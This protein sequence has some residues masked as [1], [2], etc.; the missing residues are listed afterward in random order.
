MKKASHND[1]IIFMINHYHQRTDEF[2]KEP[3]KRTEEFVDK[4]KKEV[5]YS[6]R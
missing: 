6:R 2:I 1:R 5:E 3:V 4:L